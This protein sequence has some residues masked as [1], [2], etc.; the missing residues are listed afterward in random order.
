MLSDDTPIELVRFG[1]PKPDR[2]TALEDFLFDAVEG[3][4]AAEIEA[5]LTEA[6]IDVAAFQERA[7]VAVEEGF[8]KAY[9]AQTEKVMA[10]V[11]Q[12][13][14]YM[15]PVVRHDDFADDDDNGP[16]YGSWVLVW[17][18]V[19]DTHPRMVANLLDQVQAEEMAEAYRTQ[20]RIVWRVCSATEITESAK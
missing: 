5:E 17:S 2:L 14:N 12:S 18:G 6:G 15:N 9:A 19:N 10:E 3:E 8:R 4:T 16:W 13:P 11:D 1:P 7:M 20:G